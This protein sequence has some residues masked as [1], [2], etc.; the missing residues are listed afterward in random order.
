MNN[1][2][3]KNIEMRNRGMETFL[4]LQEEEEREKRRKRP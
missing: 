4:E 2:A 1:R 3:E